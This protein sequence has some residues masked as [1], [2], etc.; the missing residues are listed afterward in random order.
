MYRVVLSQNLLK[1]VNATALSRTSSASYYVLARVDSS[2]DKFTGLRGKWFSSFL[3]NSEL[4]K[5]RFNG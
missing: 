1:L 5:H 3:Q 4:L 2:C